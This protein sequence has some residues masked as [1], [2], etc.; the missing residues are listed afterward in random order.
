MNLEYI[1]QVI[2]ISFYPLDASKL[3][4]YLFGHKHGYMWVWCDDD[5][6]GPGMYHS[7]CKY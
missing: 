7:E 3:L 6:R 1:L 5:D 4:T 2:S